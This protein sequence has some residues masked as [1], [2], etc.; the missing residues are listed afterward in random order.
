MSTLESLSLLS[1][2][3]GC[4]LIVSSQ[5]LSSVERIGEKG[6]VEWKMR[7]KKRA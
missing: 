4:L 7:E 5:D 1:L 3:D 6:E 2:L